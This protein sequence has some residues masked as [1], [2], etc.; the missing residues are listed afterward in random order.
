MLT[1]SADP[2]RAGLP[3]RD[4]NQR[5]TDERCRPELQPV[6]P[7]DARPPP[8]PR[9]RAA[10]RGRRH[11]QV[12]AANQ[13]Q[14]LDA[15]HFEQRHQREQHRDEQADGQPLGDRRRRQAVGDSAERLPPA[16]PE[17]PRMP[18]AARATPSRL[19]AV[20][21]STTCRTYVRQHFGGRGAEALE[22]GDAAHLLPDEDPRH[23]PDAD[24]AEHDDDEADQAEV[25]L[26]PLEVLADLILGGSV[27]AGTSTNWSRN[28]A[29]D[30][31]GQRLDCRR[32]LT[33]S[34]I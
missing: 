29:A 34:R 21:S 26:G 1:A 10:G 18:A 6:E 19:P 30:V 17:S 16:T 32:R 11:R 28:I 31:A 4:A 25:V 3:R 27:R 9:R 5:R 7:G 20:A 13:Q 2:P 14:R 33:F 23:A 24:A 15:A 8:P 22:D 12:G